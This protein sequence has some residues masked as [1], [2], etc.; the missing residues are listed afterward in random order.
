MKPHFHSI[1]LL[2]EPFV[3]VDIEIIKD[4]YIRSYDRLRKIL[5]ETYIV[6]HDAFRLHAWKEFFIDN[7]FTNVILDT[8]MYQC[9]DGRMEKFTIK[10]HESEALKRTK[11]LAEIEEFVPVV[12]GEWS[13]GLTSN[14][15]INEKTMKEAMTKYASAQL[16]AMREC[17]GHIFWAYRVKKSFSGWCFK[18]LVEDGIINIEEFVK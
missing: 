6:M 2:N 15:F 16:E 13:L 8:H 18:D 3:S 12:V 7:E 1:Q 10:E 11:R 4:F 17:S 5:P 14:E 9:F